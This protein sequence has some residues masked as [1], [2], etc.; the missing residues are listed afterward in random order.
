MLPH[1]AIGN[2]RHHTDRS[3]S[4][5]YAELHQHWTSIPTLP[6]LYVH[7]RDDGCMAAAFTRWIPSALSN[8]GDVAVVDHAGHFVQLEQPEKVADL[9][10]RAQPSDGQSSGAALRIAV[11][12]TDA[13]ALIS[14]RFFSGVHRCVGQAHEIVD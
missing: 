6:S 12:D 14:A 13:A 1:H 9:D 4:A 8:R 7:G 3:D 11:R 2:R 10:G 5:R